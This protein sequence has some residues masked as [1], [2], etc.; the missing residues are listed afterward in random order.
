MSRFTF[1]PKDKTITYN[2]KPSDLK[3]AQ[4]TYGL[5]KQDNNYFIRTATSG[6]TYAIEGKNSEYF[7][8]CVIPNCV[9][10]A[11]GRFNE[12]IHNEKPIGKNEV[13]PY[14]NAGDM[15][16]NCN[17]DILSTGKTPK[18]GAVIVWGKSDGAGH[19]EIV[20]KIVLNDNGTIAS[21][22]TSG[23]GYSGNLF[24]RVKKRT[25]TSASGYTFKGFIYNP[26]I[27]ENV[28]T[29][30]DFPPEEKID[31]VDPKLQGIYF[32]AA[33]SD[34]I[35]L[36]TGNN[37]KCISVKNSLDKWLYGETTNRLADLK[38]YAAAGA[39][40]TMYDYIY[41]PKPGT[42]ILKHTINLNF[43]VST[44]GQTQGILRGY[45]PEDAVITGTVVQESSAGK[46]PPKLTVIGMPVVTK[47]G[48]KTL[49]SIGSGDTVGYVN[50]YNS[51]DA[52]VTI[53][54]VTTDDADFK[55]IYGINEF[56]AVDIKAAT[57][58]WHYAIVS[59]DC[60]RAA[61]ATGAYSGKGGPMGAGS[62][63]TFNNTEYTIK[64][65]LSFSYLPK[66]FTIALCGGGG[67]GG[68]NASAH[69]G[70]GGGAIL[71]ANINFDKSDLFTITLGTGGI[72]SGTTNGGNGGNSVIYSGTTDSSIKIT[73]EGGAGGQGDSSTTLKTAKGGEV[74]Y[75]QTSDAL[76]NGGLEILSTVQ[77]GESTGTIG[78]T[79]ANFSE[80][81]ESS[82]YCFDTNSK[83]SKI[84]CNTRT[85]D[86]SGR[87][88]GGQSLGTGGYYSSKN[89]YP[90]WGGGGRASD[91]SG[92]SA[93]NCAGG[94]GGFIMWY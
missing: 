9:G 64:T 7:S 59:S 94:P 18:L 25:S 5:P 36:F 11:T 66:V 23:S 28:W 30:E 91:A 31:P 21:F 33:D 13:L 89:Y 79:V 26:A 84:I 41:A 34:V 51:T 77:G 44:S 58:N 67:A 39:S 42:N 49:G 72:Q 56:I 19:A 68:R 54:R 76:F 88:Q 62:K 61:G 20:E 87:G 48:K 53:K 32:Y 63:F 40:E 74:S 43:D 70:G 14:C 82:F 52:T 35:D 65:R 1:I 92:D 12:I 3:T 86:K 45:A 83:K 71:I 47:D 75:T 16:A 60:D 73:V 6:W 55:N 81:I 90:F 2:T 38:K 22:F 17:K 37:S 29:V 50:R 57:D 10:Y 15:I 85:G 80:K 46:S 8:G 93:G 78:K 27:P 69:S 4:N 24:Y